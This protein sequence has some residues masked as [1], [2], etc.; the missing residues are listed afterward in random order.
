MSCKRRE[1]LERQERQDPLVFY[2]LSAATIYSVQHL[3]SGESAE[4]LEA[5]S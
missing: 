3:V 1:G 5:G 4:L 2:H